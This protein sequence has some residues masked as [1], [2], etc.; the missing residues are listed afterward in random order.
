ML[1]TARLRLTANACRSDSIGTGH[2]ASAGVLILD[3]PLNGLD[4]WSA[5]KPI[6]LFRN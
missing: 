3:E 2:R 6:A 5:P 4:P 1:L